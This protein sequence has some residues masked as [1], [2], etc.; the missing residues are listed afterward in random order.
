MQLPWS[1]WQPNFAISYAD[2]KPAWVASSR[3]ASAIAA[4][5]LSPMSAMAGRG[6]SAST[7]SLVRSGSG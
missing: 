1:G 4:A 6:S 5:W 2:L 7:H 3:S